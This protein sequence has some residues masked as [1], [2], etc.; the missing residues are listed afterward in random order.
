M[1]MIAL[2]QFITS[3]HGN[4]EK[5]TGSSNIF[6]FDYQHFDMLHNS[7]S[8]KKQNTELE[9]SLYLL[10]ALRDFGNDSTF[11]VCHTS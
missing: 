11:M 8:I 1:K 6:D 7:I 4:F 3:F 10:F 2:D 5:K 9:I